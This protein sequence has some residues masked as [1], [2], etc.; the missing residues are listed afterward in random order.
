[1]KELIVLS[2]FALAFACVLV[3]W[4]SMFLDGWREYR[5]AFRRRG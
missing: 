3:G 1:M 4:W 5:K 2:L